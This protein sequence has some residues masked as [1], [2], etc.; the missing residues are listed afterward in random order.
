MTVD[1]R[2]AAPSDAEALAKLGRRSFV[3]TF[4]HLYSPEDLAENAT[5]FALL[6]K[7][8]FRQVPKLYI[9]LLTHQKLHVQFW[10]VSIP[11]NEPFDLPANF[12]FFSKNEV[13]TLPKPIL[14]DT[15]LKEEKYL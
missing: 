9:H 8:R 13:E 15:V 3:E 6:S 2:N 1:F 14:I 5:L 12:Y 7:G 4:G 11:E 10:W